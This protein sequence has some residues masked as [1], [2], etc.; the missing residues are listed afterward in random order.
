MAGGRFG[1]DRRRNIVRAGK[2]VI[3]VGGVIGGWTPCDGNA[4]SRLRGDAEVAR[5]GRLGPVAS[6]RIESARGEY[7]CCGEQHD[8]AVTNCVHCS[9][10]VEDY[11]FSPV[12]NRRDRSKKGSRSS[13][14]TGIARQS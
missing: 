10:V 2:V 11:Y 3:K 5:S 7:E 4:V 1:Q 13:L 14:G 12:S 9:P 6:G 8:C